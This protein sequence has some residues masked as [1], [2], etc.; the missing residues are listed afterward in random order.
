MTRSLRFYGIVLGALLATTTVATTATP[1]AAS[2]TT[3]T[4]ADESGDGLIW[5]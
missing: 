5:D 1:F 4:Q 2:Q 3:H